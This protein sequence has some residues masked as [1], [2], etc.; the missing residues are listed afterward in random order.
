VKPFDSEGRLLGR[1]GH[2]GI[3]N[4]GWTPAGVVGLAV[5][6]DGQRATLPVVAAE[7]FEDIWGDAEGRVVVFAGP[8]PA[9]RDLVRV[10]IGDRAVEIAAPALAEGITS[11]AIT[12]WTDGRL[13][14]SISIFRRPLGASWDPEEVYPPRP[15]AVARAIALA[16]RAYQAGANLEETPHD[17]V[18]RVA[19]AKWLDPVL[20]ALAFHARE[21][22]LVAEAATLH[23]DFAA[24]LR[25]MRETIRRNMTTHFGALPDARI[26]A[27][28]QPEPAARQAALAA[29][30]DDPALGQPALT[31][32]LAALA[33]AAARAGRDEH[34]A[35]ARL[36]R[37]APGQVFN[38]A[39]A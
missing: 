15:G 37:I 36:D 29:L 7:G 9:P 34:W 24:H 16:S 12:A 33:Q 6:L 2:L 38:L 10:Q 13:D 3:P 22:R 25:E 28:M 26:I 21:A 11:L 23:P 39:W 17:I 8:V 4:R 20:G 1:F 35:A 18:T 5:A 27:A 14:G 31:A 30:L 32:S 19:Y